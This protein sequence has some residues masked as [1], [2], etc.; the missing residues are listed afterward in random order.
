MG[1]RPIISFLKVVTK[2]ADQM[3]EHSDGMSG[4]R[5]NRMLPVVNR[6]SDEIHLLAA[7]VGSFIRAY[8]RQNF[9]GGNITAIGAC[10]RNSLI[11]LLH[12]SWPYVTHIGSKYCLYETIATSTGQLLTDSLYIAEGGES[13][14]LEITG[15][16]KTSLT[17]IAK[18]ENPALL[19]PMLSF[20]KHFICSHGSKIEPSPQNNTMN[21][22]VQTVAKDLM[23]ISYSAVCSYNTMQGG[24]ASQAIAS[25]MFDALLSC[26]K[27]CPMFLLSLSQEGQPMGEVICSSTKS[28]LTTLKLNDMDII[29]SS[30]RFL[31]E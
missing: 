9:L 31:I 28:T 13:L 26:A 18:D 10:H 14:L 25:P 15:L 16:A 7:V 20:L 19:V 11:S 1:A 5:T 3:T 17:I 12:T 21:R 2:E 8:V 23:L 22:T 29:V 4:E 30:A 27:E 24:N 6:L